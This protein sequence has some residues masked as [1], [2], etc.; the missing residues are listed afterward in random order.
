MNESNNITKDTKNSKHDV[1]V[2]FSLHEVIG[3]M[4]SLAI[5]VEGYEQY[6][7]T[8]MTDQYRNTISYLIALNRKL[9]ES[10]DTVEFDFA[11]ITKL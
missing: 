6:H 1:L 5:L 8:N 3:I 11:R 2:P 10:L 4:Q 7:D 9:A